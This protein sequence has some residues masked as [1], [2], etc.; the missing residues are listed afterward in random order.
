MNWIALATSKWT[1]MAV[2]GVVLASV[3]TYALIEF[4]NKRYTEGV[5]TERKVWEIIVEEARQDALESRQRLAAT[6]A[7]AD[8]QSRTLTAQ[9][10]QALA[11]VQEDIANAT[12][13]DTQYNVY[14]AHH[15]GVREQSRTNLSR[16]RED[17]LS[18]LGDVGRESATG[19]PTG[20]VV[21]DDS[22]S[23]DVHFVARGMV[24]YCFG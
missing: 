15:D 21:S 18:S 20:N 7:R 13:V 11:Q 2:A 10:N 19:A 16:A 12:D 4:G 1:W 24:G 3:A 6:L 8:E 9:R 5:M 22:R 14:R 23:G 17:Y